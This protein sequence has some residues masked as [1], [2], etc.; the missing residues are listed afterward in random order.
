M[1]DDNEAPA[2]PKNDQLPMSF[3]LPPRAK[4]LEMS[5]VIGNSDKKF[6]I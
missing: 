3:K 1:I 5:E 6:S 2:N 4:N